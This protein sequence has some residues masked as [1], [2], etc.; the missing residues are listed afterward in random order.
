MAWDPSVL[1]ADNA[2]AV[3][4]PMLPGPRVDPQPVQYG[5]RVD[6]LL[7]SQA[8]KSEQ[9]KGWLLLGGLGLLAWAL[10]R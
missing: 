9:L 7:A 8:Q 1:Y 5:P 10:S 6:V 4:G 2:F 3:G